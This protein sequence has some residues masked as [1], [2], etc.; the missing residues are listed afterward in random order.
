MSRT[1]LFYS[2]IAA[3]SRNTHKA[4][5]LKPVQTYGFA[6]NSHWLPVAGVE[7]A[8][9]ARN[10]V[11]V[12]VKEQH[13]YS[14][15]VVTGLK[16]GVNQFV[17]AK[18][19]WKDQVYVPAFVRRYPFVLADTGLPEPTLTICIDETYEGWGEHQGDA[20]FAPDGTNTA[21]LD[22]R[23]RFMNGLHA[24]MK[25]TQVFTAE[26]E[27]LGLLVERTLSVP[28]IN[29][30]PF[31]IGD[32]FIVDEEQ[33]QKHDIRALDKLNRTGTMGWV[34]AHLHSLGNLSMMMHSHQS[35]NRSAKNDLVNEAVH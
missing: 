4:L 20:L 7:F 32:V 18:G 11:I 6:A 33:L 23:V 30:H 16:V 3:L 1:M 27:H 15:L 34:F 25:R 24:E 8:S 5:H 17:D 21:F 26:L 12:F 9:V 31:T 19:R 10:Y 22:E 14:P 28:D 13:G 35:P 29:G 2:K